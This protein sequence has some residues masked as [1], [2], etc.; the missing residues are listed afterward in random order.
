MGFAQLGRTEKLSAF[1]TLFSISYGLDRSVG[2]ASGRL[3]TL[4]VPLAGLRCK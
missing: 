3:A 2:L 1:E 4:A